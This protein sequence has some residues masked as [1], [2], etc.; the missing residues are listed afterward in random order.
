MSWVDAMQLRRKAD[1]IRS[2][3]WFNLVATITFVVVY[4]SEAAEIVLAASLWAAL[5]M[6]LAYAF[7]WLIDKRADRV[8]GL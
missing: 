5:I 2:V 6:A 4:A 7:G 1:H 3:G 8:V